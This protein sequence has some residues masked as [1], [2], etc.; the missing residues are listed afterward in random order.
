MKN[1]PVQRSASLQSPGLAHCTSLYSSL[2][3]SIVPRP[4]SAQACFCFDRI[5]EEE[6]Y[7]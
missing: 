5:A 6:L 2:R 4:A 7:A 3:A 1:M